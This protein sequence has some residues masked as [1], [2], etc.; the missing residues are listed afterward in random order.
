MKLLIFLIQNH[1]YAAGFIVCSLVSIITSSLP[2]PTATDGKWY[3][4]FFNFMHTLTGIVGRIPQVRAFM[5]LQENPTTMAGIVAQA[6]AKAI[7]PAT[8]GISQKAKE[9][10]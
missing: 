6:D 3:V 8:Q 7:D 9:N 5:G 1:P 2:S 4:F 10:P